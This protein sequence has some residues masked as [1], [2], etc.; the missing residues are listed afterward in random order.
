MPL[1]GLNTSK[2]WTQITREMREELRKWGITQYHMPY[3]GGSERLGSVTVIV[4]IKGQEK[5]I[6]CDRFHEANWP[7]RD[8]VAIKGAI[9]AA[10]LA[11]QRGLGS[12]F[13][14]AYQLIALPDPDDPYYILGV[15]PQAGIEDIR[16]AYRKRVAE[17]HPDQGG[18]REMFERV[19]EAGQRLGVS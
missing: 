5:R 17:A 6:T 10:R 15:N 16:Y 13:A 7:E 9:R 14:Q 1:G 12:V 2:N 11:D 4:T 3:K 19:I 8:Y 18:S